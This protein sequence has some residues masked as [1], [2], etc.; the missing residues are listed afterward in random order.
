MKCPYCDTELEKIGRVGFNEPIYSCSN[1][2]C[3]S[4][5]FVF[6]SAKAWQKVVSLQ[7]IRK[8][9]YKFCAKY[10][11]KNRE[12]VNQYQR[13]WYHRNKYKKESE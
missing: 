13:E 5:N 10:R 9:Q 3:E 12:K 7:K 11:E 8:R 2:D 6:G 4:S 1:P